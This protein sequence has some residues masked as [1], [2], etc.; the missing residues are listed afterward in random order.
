VLLPVNAERPDELAHFFLHT[1]FQ[2]RLWVRIGFAAALVDIRVKRT[3]PSL[4]ISR[5]GEGSP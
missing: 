3:V 4:Q 5:F 2:V 1:T